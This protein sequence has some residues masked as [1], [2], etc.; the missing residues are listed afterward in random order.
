MSDPNTQQTGPRRSGRGLKIALGLSLGLNLLIVGLVVGALLSIG[1]G[2]GPDGDPR[3][4]SLGLGPFA[5]ALPREDRQA[6]TDRIDRDAL[7]ADRRE[8]G[9]A[10]ADLRAALLSQPFDRA[11]AEAALSRSRDAAHAAQGQGHRA[12]LDH[13]ETLTP[14]QRAELVERL[15]RALRRMGGPEGRR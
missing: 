2:R 7:R 11:A 8:M 13:I 14:S 6:V 1:P 9:Q 3:L 12:L 4:R 5:I 10:L 15:G